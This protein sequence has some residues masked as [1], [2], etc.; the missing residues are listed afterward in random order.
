MK[1]LFFCLLLLVVLLAGCSSDSDRELP[2][3][4]TDILKISKSELPTE[5]NP[6]TVSGPV[7]LVDAPGNTTV[8][9]FGEKGAYR[10][11]FESEGSL[12]SVSP[13]ESHVKEEYAYTVGLPLAAFR[14]AITD[15]SSVTDWYDCRGGG[16]TDDISFTFLGDPQLVGKTS[17]AA[18]RDALCFFPDSDFV[19][20]AG[21]MVNNS[22]E[23]WQYEAGA[24]ACGESG[25]PVASA[26]GNHDD[27]ELFN[28]YFGIDGMIR[29][30]SDYAFHV[31]NVLFLCFDS[32]D[33]EMGNR[34][35]FVEEAAGQAEWDWIIV[36]MH[37]SLFPPRTRLDY[38][39]QTRFETFTQLFSEYDIDLV[40]SG[41]D[42]LYARTY[43]M[44]GGQRTAS[45]ADAAEKS[46][47]QTLY[48]TAGSCSGSKFYA[49]EQEPPDYLCALG[50]P[51]TI[52]VIQVTVSGNALRINA[53]SPHNAEVFDSFTLTRKEGHKPV[54][55]A[56]EPEQRRPADTHLL[57]T[58][59][60]YLLSA[61]L[62]NSAIGVYPVHEGINWVNPYFAD[63][64]ALALL[65]CGEYN[66]VREYILWRI[67][68]LNPSGNDINGM[69][70][71]IYDYH[72]TVQDGEQ[73]D[74]TSTGDYDSVDSYAASFLL[75]LNEYRKATNDTALICEKDRFISGVIQL[76]NQVFT[77][78]LTVAR[79]DYPICYLMDNCEVALALDAAAELIDII[80]SEKRP[81]SHSLPAMKQTCLEQRRQILERIDGLW[82]ESTGAYAYAVS[83]DGTISPSGKEAFYP[84]AICQIYPILF[85]VL[86]PESARAQACYQRFC[87][88]W[89]WENLEPLRSG[90]SNQIWAM[91][92]C[93]AVQMGDTD[94]AEQFMS[95]YM[96]YA[97]SEAGQPIGTQET[98][99]VVL[100]AT[101]GIE[102][103]GGSQ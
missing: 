99:W 101:G 87:E 80:V 69:A 40:L 8:R 34:R 62:P 56:P 14:Y 46:V 100:A 25:F 86:S 30:G 41:H 49:S 82:E 22:D 67:S 94:R 57:Q 3:G 19:L 73:T 32:N 4:R 27:P 29:S 50:A 23:I 39:A 1:R 36:Y 44:Q 58:A 28:F 10:L 93:A 9:W 7:C 83:S 75:L 92:A 60:E 37:H 26:R 66:A 65:R 70:Y 72:I 96:E 16:E 48:V 55:D 38:D 98:A 15:G 18:F 76:L 95:S 35:A 13:T 89:S 11:I 6:L 64:A 79:P 90:A 52:S 59:R 63:Y 42:H 102:Q 61:R 33:P 78:G 20:L 21:D 31:G 71:T 45:P 97:A 47:G 85:G 77:D 81:D 43:L 53:V 74:Q 88:D 84:D 12:Y 103:N 17:T 51:E 68:R 2:F 54:P 91:A 24:D 5:E